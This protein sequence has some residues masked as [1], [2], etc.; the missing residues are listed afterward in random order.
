MRVVIFHQHDPGTS[1]VGGIPTFLN[2][3]IKYSP[4]DFTVDLVGLTTEPEKRPVGQWMEFPVGYRRYRF[5]PV[6]SAQPNLRGKL[7]ITFRLVGGI[8]RHW[9]L[10]DLRNAIL[11][12]HRIEPALALLGSNN[13]KALFLH[14]HSKDYRNE[15]TEAIWGKLPAAYQ[16]LE[17]SLIRGMGRIFIVRE[18]AASDYRVQYPDISNRVS[19]LPTWVDEEVFISLPEEQR[20]RHRA[21]FAARHGFDAAGKLLLFV[22]RFEGQKDPM[23]L[24]ESF[25]L[26]LGTVKE[27]T[28]VMVGEGKMEPQI[29]QFIEQNGLQKRVLMVGPRPQPEV[30]LW[31]NAADSLVLSS[32]YEGM[33]RVV[34]EGLHCGLP[35]VS[36]D[37][38][39]ARRLIGDNAGG[40]LVTE[41][42][43]EPFARAVADLLANPP[44][45]QSCE[46]QSAPFTA[47][48]ILEQV[49]KA[50]R[51]MKKRN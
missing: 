42:G 6:I 16:A 39:E 5:L 22:G 28:L 38:G 20:K 29:R 27:A 37:A 40:R 35:A 50:Y 41:P 8:R 7:P 3:F 12:I 44:S 10:L 21:E 14:N 51:L 34:V 25:R 17:W 4:P 46:G 31:M 47:R 36:T 11:E 9:R 49:Y 43:P 2:T 26:L 15:K 48:L 32:A 33:P 45:R 13:P 1:H 24:L 18:D 30:A 19:F 23:R